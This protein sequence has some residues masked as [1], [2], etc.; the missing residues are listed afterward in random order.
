M[1]ELSQEDFQVA[2]DESL[3]GQQIQRQT[4][5]LEEMEQQT[6]AQVQAVEDAGGVGPSSGMAQAEMIHDKLDQLQLTLMGQG[7]QQPIFQLDRET[8]QNLQEGISVEVPEVGAQAQANAQADA[9]SEAMV[10]ELQQIKDFVS[11]QDQQGLASQEEFQQMSDHL[12]QLV[13]SE[14]ISN[15][16][17]MQ[18]SEAM[19]AEFQQVEEGSLGGDFSAQMTQLIGQVEEGVGQPLTDVRQALINASGQM[20]LGDLIANKFAVL[21]GTVR[22]GLATLRDS[23]ISAWNTLK[24]GVMG[25]FGGQQ[26]LFDV[27]GQ[28]VGTAISGLGGMIAGALGYSS[29]GQAVWGSIQSAFSS[30]FGG[31][32][33]ATSL[34][35]TAG[36]ALGAGVILDIFFGTGKT[37]GLVGM[38][39]DELGGVLPLIEWMFGF[40]Q[41]ISVSSMISSL[42][43]LDDFNMGE[44]FA[45]RFRAGV[46]G[47]KAMLSKAWEEYVV[48]PITVFMN[49]IESIMNPLETME[50]LFPLTAGAVEMLWDSLT[51]V[52]SDI[53]SWFAGM[54]ASIKNLF[55]DGLNWLVDQMGNLFDMAVDGVTNVI[56]NVGGFIMDLPGMWWNLQKQ[57]F[58]MIL[59]GL[60]QVP[61]QMLGIFE[62]ALRQVGLDAVADGI[63]MLSSALTNLPG[64]IMS[65]LQNLPGMLVKA[66]KTIPGQ[67]TQAIYELPSLIWDKMQ[68]LPSMIANQIP[69]ASWFGGGGDEGGGGGGAEPQS[70]IPWVPG[71]AQGGVIKEPSIAIGKQ[72]GQVFELAEQGPEIVA[73]T[74][75][76]SSATPPDKTAG[77]EGAQP[78]Q[79]PESQ[80]AMMSDVFA[81]DERGEGD[82]GGERDSLLRQILEAVQNIGGNA[83]ADNTGAVPTGLTDTEA[84]RIS[85]GTI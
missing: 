30:F 35:G 58:R 28:A 31:T 82:D 37:A 45:R 39:I 5:L 3:M 74:A 11:L 49:P 9:Q 54:G 67:I 6:Q 33:L 56:S 1:P 62:S 68:N 80:T 15:D 64:Q 4:Q 34:F 63:G 44:L 14:D 29:I 8:I 78:Q 25:V 17:L 47:F 57:G 79:Q 26:S 69:G 21:R 52:A 23:L 7:L 59:N 51:N 55:M 66:V 42:F 53:G 76:V 46:Q 70:D 81:Q 60:F 18:L 19:Q 12:Q 75:D 71:L 48:D 41:D 2:M 20:S 13:E 61:G 10:D 77:I 36:F 85:R 32:S 24:D 22:D 16:Q 72:S 27:I 73:P 43:G 38:A 84:L 83:G 65:A 50:E 40:E